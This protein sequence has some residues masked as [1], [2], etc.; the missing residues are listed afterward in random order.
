MAIYLHTVAGCPTKSTL[1]RA[2]NIGCFITWIGLT[3]KII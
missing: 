3:S 2:I 1:I